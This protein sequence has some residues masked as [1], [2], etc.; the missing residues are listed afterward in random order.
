MAPGPVVAVVPI[1]T[2]AD[3]HQHLILFNGIAN[4]SFN[5]RDLAGFGREHEGVHFHGFQSEQVVAFFYSLA[6][7]NHDRGNA[8][9]ERAGHICRSCGSGR[10]SRNWLSNWNRRCRRRLIGGN[11]WRRGRCRGSRELARNF[12]HHFHRNIVGAAIDGNAKPFYHEFLWF[13]VSGS[14]VIGKSGCGLPKPKRSSAERA[15]PPAEPRP[16][17]TGDPAQQLRRL[18]L[19]RQVPVPPR[20]VPKQR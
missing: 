11:D 5:L 15:W 2:S 19:P 18:R 1:M 17:G 16:G 10:R 9:R 6:C 7:R 12:I 3:P 4:G 8:T 13:V 14:Y 20:C